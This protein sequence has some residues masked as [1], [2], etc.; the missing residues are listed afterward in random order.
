MK[1]KIYF[2]PF[3]G[4]NLPVEYIEEYLHEA[5]AREIIPVWNFK[6]DIKSLKVNNFPP[7][8]LLN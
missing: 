8:N 5:A 4:H 6:D 7:N 2:V 3:D 1:G